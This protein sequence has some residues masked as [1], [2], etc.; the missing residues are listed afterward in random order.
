VRVWTFR[1]M[2][3]ASSVGPS[4]KQQHFLGD[5]G[6]EETYRTY[7]A[8]TSNSNREEVARLKK[9]FLQEVLRLSIAQVKSLCRN[10]FRD[11]QVPS[12]RKSLTSSKA[13]EF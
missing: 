1:T 5:A 4:F 2:A 11:F 9:D 12:R 10:V 8:N 3:P 6:I 7:L 13:K